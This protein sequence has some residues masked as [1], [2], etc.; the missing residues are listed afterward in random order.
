MSGYAVELFYRG[1]E[2]GKPVA[3]FRDKD[4][5]AI[6]AMSMIFG[7]RGMCSARLID[8]SDEAVSEWEKSHLVNTKTE[9]GAK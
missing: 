3:M 2:N 1:E 9:G 4:S 7:Q 6:Y 8:V 5:A